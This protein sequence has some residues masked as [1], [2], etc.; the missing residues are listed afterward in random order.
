MT[1][2]IPVV[3]GPAGLPQNLQSGDTLA[4]GTPDSITLTNATGLPVSGLSNLGTGVSTLLTASPTGGISLVGSNSPALTGTPTAPTATVGTNTTQIAT[5]AF[6][7]ANAAGLPYTPAKVFQVTIDFGAP[8]KK[9]INTTFTI[10]GVTTNQN[11][12]MAP[13]LVMPSGLSVDELE[14]DTFICSAYVS[15]ADTI[16][17]I[18]QAYPGPVTGTRNFNLTIG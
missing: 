14:M 15:A 3:L 9:T 18:I 2:R 7:L 6:V 8:G 1:V 10:T 17:A 4:L 5:C 11:I 13:S 16:Q 12:V